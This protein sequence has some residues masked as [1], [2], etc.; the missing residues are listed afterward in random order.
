MIDRSAVSVQH[1]VLRWQ[2]GMWTVRDLGS[3]NGTFVNGQRVAAGPA[4][5]VELVEGDELTFA[6]G[7]EVWSLVDAAPPGSLLIPVDDQGNPKTDRAPYRL[8]V[9]DVVAV[10][11]SDNPVASVF[12]REGRWLLERADALVELGHGETVQVGDERFSVHLS[13]FATGTVDPEQALV[14]HVVQ[15]AHLEICVSA[16]EES[17]A[18][19]VTIGRDRH[20]LEARTFLYLLAYLARVRIDDVAAGRAEDEAGWVPVE[21]ACRDL[22]LSSNEALGL[23]VHRCRKAMRE[24][25]VDDPASVIDRSRRG[26]LRIGVPAARLDVRLE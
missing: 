25:H 9:S 24:A 23:L 20:T 19:A 22:Q 6:E 2:A 26:L 8:D 12:Q 15:N 21:Q 13:T 1:A 17:A 10:P 11:S 4:D 7:D 16:D 18:L 5:I 3:R 14:E